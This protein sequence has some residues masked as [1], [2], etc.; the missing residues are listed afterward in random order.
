MTPVD[1]DRLKAQTYFR[2]NPLRYL[3]HLKYM[4]LYRDI[5]SCTVLEHQ[6]QTAVLLR[7]PANRVKR[8]AARYPQA[9]QV[10]MPVAANDDLTRRLLDHIA[11]N[12][13]RDHA[14]IIKFCEP[15]TEAMFQQ[16][17]PLEPVRHVMS[18]TTIPEA[19][20]ELAP[21]VSIETQPRASCI[22][23]YVENDYSHAEMTNYFANDA[24]AFTIYDYD[25]PISTCI[26]FRFF[27]D[28]WEIGGV[29]TREAMRH[30]GYAR[31]VVQT[32][33][34]YV[35]QQGKT[36]RY[37]VESINI[38]SIRLAE[39]LGM[40]PGAVFQHYLLPPVSRRTTP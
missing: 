7:Y 19:R 28:V 29:H 18:Y 11:L 40:R 9:D 27:E 32:A 38:P 25:D 34:S 24:L 13:E 36:P 21:N 26:A 14:H 8:D 12:L 30:K 5:I 6:H 4:H 20:Y 31:Q 39:S 1:V 16:H 33:L 17:L 2:T 3:V 15:S 35:L 22:A 23:F 37:Q 10:L